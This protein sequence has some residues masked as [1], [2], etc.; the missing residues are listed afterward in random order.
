MQLLLFCVE[1]ESIYDKPNLKNRI[2]NL[3]SHV[4]QESEIYAIKILLCITIHIFPDLRLPS[5]IQT[6]KKCLRQKLFVKVE[7]TEIVLD[8]V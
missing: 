7:T 2:A 1:K 6:W 3:G 5:L 4:D 8:H